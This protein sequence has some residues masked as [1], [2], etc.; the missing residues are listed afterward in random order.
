MLR[1]A[2]ERGQVRIVND[3]T[4]TPTYSADLAR[5]TLQLLSTDSFGL[6]NW[7]NSGSCTWYQFACEIFRQAGISP[8][9]LPITS[10]QYGARAVLPSYSVL[11]TSKYEKLGFSQ[12]RHWKEALRA[13]LD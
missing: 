5:A 11:S 13:Y 12:P 1:V 6:Y 7:T 9:C 3:Q 8:E 4:C 10:E 2:T